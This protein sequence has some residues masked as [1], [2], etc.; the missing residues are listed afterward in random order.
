MVIF[1]KL[2]QVPHSAILMF[3]SVI[4]I[5]FILNGQPAKSCFFKNVMSA[6]TRRVCQLNQSSLKL[7]D[8]PSYCVMERIRTTD[9]VGTT[10]G[11]F[12]STT[13]GYSE[14]IYR[15]Q[16]QWTQ[17]NLAQ[18]TAVR[19][20]TES[21]GVPT[22]RPNTGGSPVS[23]RAR[24]RLVNNTHHLYSCVTVQWTFT[25]IDPR[26]TAHRTTAV[27]LDRLNLVVR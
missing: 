23:S 26:L 8:G 16:Q 22:A 1:Q 4:V 7:C 18:R 27:S 3:K 12:L 20:S 25:A 6:L 11:G 17:M 10:H 2:R 19:I 21:S 9:T 15:Q 24:T 14:R 13:P 5:F